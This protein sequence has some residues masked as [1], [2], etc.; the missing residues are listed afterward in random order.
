VSPSVSPSE[1]PGG[2]VADYLFQQD[3]T[4][5]QSQ[6]FPAG[7]SYITQQDLTGGQT[8]V[9]PSVGLGTCPLGMGYLGFVGVGD[10]YTFDTSCTGSQGIV[11]S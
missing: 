1:V 4:G 7:D 9:F 8:Q 11:Y 2:I 6:L 10:D 3:L 5:S